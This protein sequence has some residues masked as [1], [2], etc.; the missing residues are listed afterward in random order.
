MFREIFFF[1]TFTLNKKKHASYSRTG[2]RGECSRF[3]SHFS[4][5]RPLSGPSRGPLRPALPDA[6]PAPPPQAPFQPVRDPLCGPAKAVL[7]PF[8]A[9][10][11][12]HYIIIRPVR[13]Q[14]P[15][16]KFFCSAGQKAVDNGR[17][18]GK[19]ASGKRDDGAKRGKE[20]A[21]SERGR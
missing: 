15:P 4:L 19:I 8:L 16:W 14:A 13:C 18:Y 20:S 10:V 17:K 12:V 5:D 3:H 7:F 6:L 2:I 21:Q 1:V 9:L 11:T